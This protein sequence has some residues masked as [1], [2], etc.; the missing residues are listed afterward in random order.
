M[1]PRRSARLT[2]SHK[3]SPQRSPSPNEEVI[4]RKLRVKRQRTGQRK[5]EAGDGAVNTDEGSNRDIIDIINDTHDAKRMAE[6][7]EGKFVEVADKG[8]DESDEDCGSGTSSIASGPSL[9]YH[10]TTKK[11]RPSRDLC[12]ACKKLYQKAKKS[13]APIKNKLLDNNPKSLTCDQWVLIKKWKPRRLPNARG[14]LLTHV[15]LVEKRLQVNKGVKQS[16]QY[17]GESTACSRP[18]TFLQRN[19]RRCVRVPVK[20]ERKKNERRKR[21]REDSQ[22]SRVAKQQRLHSNSHRQHIGTSSTDDSGLHLTSGHGSSG[23]FESCSDQETNS[24]A[25]TDV[26][27][28]SIPSTKPREVPPRQK[29][30]KKTSGFRDLLAQ[31]RGNSSMIVRETR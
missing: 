19:L 25:D 14:K 2:K 7:D 3:R 11:R 12:S 20:K 9:L 8:V 24:Q 6:E 10:T 13:K 22:G 16:E 18:H 30:P 21:P 4:Q 28:E 15:Q 31:L 1:Y 26:T 17:V 23:G 29:T 27:V 5:T